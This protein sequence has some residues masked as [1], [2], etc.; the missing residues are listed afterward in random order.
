MSIMLCI[1]CDMMI[2]TDLEEYEYDIQ[3]CIDCLSD[4]ELEKWE[5][6]K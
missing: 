3:S 5:N 1:R 2:D 4:E 6:E